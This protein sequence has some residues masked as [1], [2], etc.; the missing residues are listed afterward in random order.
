M[1]TWGG[2]ACVSLLVLFAL[3]ALVVVLVVSLLTRR[4]RRELSEPYETTRRGAVRREGRTAA[5]G[6]CPE[7]GAALPVDAPA[8]SDPSS[9]DAAA[10]FERFPVALLVPASA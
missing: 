7:C 5:P 6:R 3:A 10:V 4:P 2:L 1:I 9:L 8:G